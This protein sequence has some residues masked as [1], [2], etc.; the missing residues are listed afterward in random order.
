MTDRPPTRP[1]SR[2]HADAELDVMLAA[3]RLGGPT[4]DRIFD[5]VM[6]RV[7]GEP[8]RRLGWR[9]IVLGAAMLTA[10]AATLLLV[11]RL[12][13]GPQELDFAAKGAGS[14]LGS[15]LQISCAGAALTACPV[16]SRLLFV[17]EGPTAGYLA[18]YAQPRAGSERIWY[19][20]ADGVAP[21]VAHSPGTQ[22][23]SKAI[24]IGSEHAPGD[25]DVH[26]LLTRVPLS[27]A[28]ILQ[29]VRSDD[30]LG[31]ARVP[32]H[33]VAADVPTP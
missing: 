7:G 18:A 17:A 29:G 30:L 3:G 5:A 4:N 28:A 25:Y 31:E 12:R 24:Q 9:S 20:S 33:V 19:F 10:A 11:P 13:G 6:E 32:L 27:R 26:L 15:L 23:A 16:G 1:T 14:P 22:V 2:S 8:R 21:A